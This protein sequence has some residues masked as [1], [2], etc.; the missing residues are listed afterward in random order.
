MAGSMRG[1]DRTT[2]LAR[3]LENILR[4]GVVA[5]VDHAAQRCT[6]K[7][8]QLLTAPLKWI[9]LRAGTARTRWAPSPGE[10][11][12][13]LNPGGDTTRG[14]VLPALFS[15]AAPAPDAGPNA[16]I[17]LYPDGASIAYDPNTHVL[18]ATLP[19]SGKADV[20]APA[21]ISI[22]GD[23]HIDGKLHVSDDVTAD[24]TVT[25]ATD[26]VAAGVSL[27]KHPHDQVMRGADRS[28]PPAAN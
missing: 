21:G 22:R 10:Q 4:Y 18:T 24:T 2:E 27:T 6:V 8:G 26:I 17:T 25:A 16:N 9:T 20:T 28:G 5:S 7:T 13:L 3:L 1:M 11:V 14:C 15:D 19:A 23:V 12:L